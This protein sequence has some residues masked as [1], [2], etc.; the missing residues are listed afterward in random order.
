MTDKIQLVGL[1]NNLKIDEMASKVIEVGDVLAGVVLDK[2]ADITLV[3]VHQRLAK[4][5]GDVEIV[6]EVG[7]ALRLE[8]TKITEEAIQLKYINDRPSDTT[9]SVSNEQ[10]K[11]FEMPKEYPKEL[12][13]AGKV[14]SVEEVQ[15]L[16]AVVAK[17]E[18][19]LTSLSDTMTDKDVRA[20]LEGGINPSKLS[21][22]MMASIVKHNKALLYDHNMEQLAIEAEKALDMLKADYEDEAELKAIVIELKKHNLPVTRKQV[23]KVLNALGKMDQI[24]AKID[25]KWMNVLRDEGAVTLD[26]VYKKVNEQKVI[27]TLP[28]I[29][30]SDLEVLVKN[31]FD[32][33]GVQVDKQNVDAA[34]KLMSYE[35]P[36]TEANLSVAIAPETLLVPEDSRQLIHAFV[37]KID[38]NEAPTKAEVIRI[39]VHENIKASVNE[40]KDYVD[41]N[42]KGAHLAL[43]T[44]TGQEQIA[45]SDVSLKARAVEMIQ[46]IAAITY[47]QVATTS[48]EH[49]I[50]SIE[51][52]EATKADSVNLEVLDQP[53]SAKIDSNLKWMEEIRIRM[54]VEAAMRLEGKGIK[55]ETRSLESLAGDLKSSDEQVYKALAEVHNVSVEK[56]EVVVDETIMAYRRMSDYVNQV[57]AFVA[58][59][60][61]ATS[62]VIT[63]R[64]MEVAYDQNMTQI[65]KDLGDKIERTF[66][67]IEPMLREIGVEPTKETIEAGQILARNGMA[68]TE[69]NILNI[70]LIQQKVAYVT[71][72]MSPHL[73]LE[74]VKLGVTPL[75]LSLDETIELI[76]QYDL[77]FGETQ[78]EK[79]GRMILEL[80]KDGSLTGEERESLLGIY[81]TF[82]TVVRSKGAAT[83]FVIKNE[84][85]LTIEKLFEAAKYLR[86]VGKVGSVVRA[87]IDDDFGRLSTIRR[88]SKS[89]KEQVA[90]A[91]EHMK[92]SVTPKTVS[93]YES[94][95]MEDVTPNKTTMLSKML[96]EMTLMNFAWVAEHDTLKMVHGDVG[97]KQLQSMP[98]EDITR[99]I[100]T[101]KVPPTTEQSTE[102]IEAALKFI[103][104][105]PQL[106]KNLIGTQMPI[107]PDTLLKAVE[108]NKE[109]FELLIRLREMMSSVDDVSIKEA[110]E[111]KVSS[112]AKAILSGDKTVGD[113]R[114]L[115]EEIEKAILQHKDSGHEAL[116]EQASSAIKTTQHTQMIQVSHDYYQI[117]MM[118][119]QELGQ[120]NM[121]ILNDKENSLGSDE[122]SMRVLMQFSTTNMGNVTAYMSI[123]NGNLAM[124]LQSEYDEDKGLL[125]EMATKIETMVNDTAYHLSGITYETMKHSDPVHE[126][127]S[128]DVSKQN[129]GFKNG[130]FETKV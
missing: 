99:L 32:S 46:R 57:S 13:K 44:S 73:V 93:T 69:E 102:Q 94:L 109:P 76:E 28:E 98:L 58:G 15:K 56:T 105:H 121:Y 26:K 114:A 47:S 53:S 96:M 91:I 118:I 1:T 64:H 21:I 30:K 49:E 3:E 86:K 45:L 59:K 5:S 48:L 63:V 35:L 65:R 119:G 2:G 18:N 52:I 34:I 113:L 108:L 60:G 19:Q 79:I 123:Q 37:D 81:R 103:K 124:N 16:N 122:D 8:V 70:Q 31:H 10:I 6:E 75:D 116:S 40:A 104:Q 12:I 101:L 24:R 83:G 29:S 127:I 85:P 42:H 87:D 95:V 88:D 117:P 61:E 7:E 39:K 120:L 22:D 89:I 33:I 92:L 4:L 20:M 115:V 112:T 23:D 129:I 80:Q 62:E 130:H 78:P 125:K 11:A 106:V 55:I 17:L 107:T 41:S 54:T 71:T 126:V 97:D 68:I 77:K 25:T 111:E 66:E 128:S 14:L 67:Q 38:M 36:I 84:M 50:V 74:M 82:D 100:E 9:G 90:S 43:E 110:M 72:K 27:A 51:T